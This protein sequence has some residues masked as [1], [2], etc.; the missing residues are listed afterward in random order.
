[1][2]KK[3]RLDDIIT[4]LKK[5]G[6][7]TVKYLTEELHYST[8]TINRDLNLLENQKIVKRSYGGVEL[9][10]HK[11]TPL[12]FR[13]HKMKLAK[14][15]IGKKA[16]EFICDGDTVFIDGSTTAQYIGQYIT[17]KKEL[18][19]ISNNMALLTY[20]SEYNIKCICL[21]GQI[22]EIPS[23]LG[24]METVENARKYNA[25]KM[26]FSTS[27]ISA[28][29]KIG[30]T[31]T[32]YTMHKAMAENSSKIFYLAD[33]GKIDAKAPLVL[34]DLS[35]VNSVIS[36]FNFPEKTKKSFPD[37]EFLTCF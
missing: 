5:N 18:T 13:Y 29:G 2:S 23:M 21:G 3:T 30:S 12:V 34:F 14:N 8:A 32:Y 35:G 10:E 4:I 6:Y 37:T 25:D 24:G 36:D 19:V 26:F 20:L 11:S 17:N 31:E 15:K 33:K 16:A 7:V 22:V 1:M 9:R 28:E 27:A